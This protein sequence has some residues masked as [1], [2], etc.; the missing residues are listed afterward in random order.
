M[1]YHKECEKVQTKVIMAYPKQ[2]INHRHK[3]ILRLEKASADLK[4]I[5]DAEEAELCHKEK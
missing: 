5:A 1:F 4:Q 3:E 2:Y